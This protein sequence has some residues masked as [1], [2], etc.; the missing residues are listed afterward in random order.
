MGSQLYDTDITYI[1][2]VRKGANGDGVETMVY[3]SAEGKPE[4]K[5]VEVETDRGLAQEVIAKEAGLGH[6]IIETVKKWMAGEKEVEKAKD[7]GDAKELDSFSSRISSVPDNL[8]RAIDILG[9]VI[10]WIAWDDKPDGSGRIMTAV[11][12]F[13]TYVTGALSGALSIQV[14]KEAFFAKYEETDRLM[15]D[16]PV[17]KSIAQGL[18]QALDKLETQKVIK[19]DEDTVTKEEMMEMLAPVT[20]SIEALDLKLTALE[21]VSEKVSKMETAIEGLGTKVPEI[22]QKTEEVVKAADEDK[23]KLIEVLTTITKSLDGLGTR[24]ETIEQTRGI[25]KQTDGTEVVEKQDPW[26]GVL[27]MLD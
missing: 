9:S 5:P 8:S 3:K 15:D 14:K 16:I 11:D 6:T 1:S 26:A 23:T 4:V 25:S 7:L 20:K 10:W 13:K 21:G 2:L 22:D 17:L 27:G 19:G 12:E 24:L 18:S